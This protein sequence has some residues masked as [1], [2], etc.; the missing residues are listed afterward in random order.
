M[1]R[2][3]LTCALLVLC[4]CGP[5][6]GSGAN[7]PSAAEPRQADAPPAAPGA[8]AA[9]PDD[10]V[11]GLWWV[12]APTFPNRAFLVSLE[13]GQDGEDRGGT[14]VSFDWRGTTDPESLQRRSKPVR[15]T[16]RSNGTQVH[17]EGPAPMLTESGQPTGQSGSWQLDLR[18]AELPGEPPRWSGVANHD[19][20]LTGPEGVA[21]EMERAFRRWQ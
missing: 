4:A 17:V 2:R 5:A 10:A 8:E 14:W 6:D 11:A 9:D 20:G 18:R 7:E 21:V 15:I 3:S 1:S 12:F 13:P 16:A 19:R